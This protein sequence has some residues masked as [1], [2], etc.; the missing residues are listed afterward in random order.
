MNKPQQWKSIVVV[1]ELSHMY[2]SEYQALQ[3]EL[4][5]NEYDGLFNSESS[6]RMTYTLQ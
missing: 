6:P 4:S 3:V 5:N 2:N 1:C